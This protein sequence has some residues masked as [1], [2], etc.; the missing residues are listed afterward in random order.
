[1]KRGHFKNLRVSPIGLVPKAKTAGSGWR[2]IHHLS[3]PTGR[4]VNDFIDPEF[5][6]VNILHLTRFFKLSKLGQN[7]LLA[8]IDILSVF[9]L[10]IFHPD[11]FELSLLIV[12][13]TLIWGLVYCLKNTGHF[14]HVPSLG[15]ER[16]L[17]LILHF[18]SW[19]Q[20]YFQFFCL[21]ITLRISG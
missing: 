6:S 7:A 13:E 18:W 12:L 15:E 16:K 21:G 4:S 20:L 1:M 14:F 11:D 5:T 10:M 17:C 19:C 3:H 2:I 8:K 9:R